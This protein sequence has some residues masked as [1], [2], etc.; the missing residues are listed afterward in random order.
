MFVGRF[1]IS[2]PTSDNLRGDIWCGKPP[3]PHPV[4]AK[5]RDCLVRSVYRNGERTELESIPVK[6]FCLN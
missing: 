4:F 6:D 1:T 2:A 5:L 3:E